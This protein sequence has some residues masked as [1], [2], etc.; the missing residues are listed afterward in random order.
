MT[1]ETYF[2]TIENYFSENGDPETAEGQMK[3]MRN[4]FDFFGLKAA[5]WVPYSKKLFK[6][7]GLLTGQELKTFVRLCFADDHREMHYMALQMIEKASKKR[8][9]GWDAPP[10]FIEFIEETATCKS[11]WDTID[12]I[13][14]FVGDH[15][16]RYPELRDPT[17]EKW[18]ASGNIW[19]QRL[20]LLFQLP[21]KNET[22]AE[23][24]FSLVLRLKNSNEFFIQ[25]AAGWA[26]R[27]YA[28]F[29]P[30]A[31]IN[32]IEK[33]DDLPPLTKR[34]GLKRLKKLGLYP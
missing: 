24:L 7:N 16:K 2:Q 30:E 15:F 1:A 11:W 10:D 28:N 20:C 19:L 3:Y 18:M 21:F 14:N 6:E 8:K 23:L 5:D 33:N 22:D 9:S 34:E 27:Q 29:N 17:I 25:K 32:F 4:Q 26:L 12:W 13:K 31:V